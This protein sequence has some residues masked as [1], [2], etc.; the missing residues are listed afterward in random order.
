[1]KPNKAPRY[2]LITGRILKEL[3][4]VDLIFLTQFC[5]AI[6]RI[7]YFPSQW[8]V[9][10]I[11][12]ILKPSKPAED[13]KSYRPI[14]YRPIA[15][16]MFETLLLKR[17]SPII[18][19]KN[20]I[21]T[22]QFGFRRKHVTTEQV[23]RIVGKINKALETKRYCSAAFLDISQAFDKVWHDGLLIKIKT[24]LPLNFYNIFRSYLDRRTFLV[25]HDEAVTP[26][27]DIYSGASR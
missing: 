1:M 6:L 10:Q 3:P 20:L 12:M 14:S 23:H 27:H 18:E 5:N 21:P 2:D 4:D 22:H 15:S 16:K 19:E 25:K 17:L 7:N 11:I 8:K 9:A 26:L 13:A 24:N